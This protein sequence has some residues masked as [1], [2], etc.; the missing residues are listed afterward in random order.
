M[1]ARAERDDLSQR[2]AASQA[3]IAELELA[4]RSDAERDAVTGLATLARLRAALEIEC[5]RAQRQGRPVLV[6]LLDIDGFRKI[7][8]REGHVGGDE[9]L[10]TV[11]NAIRR[12]A[13]P[14]DLVARTGSDEFG[15]MIVGVQLAE[16]EARCQGLMA[17]L[18]KERTN[19]ERGS[20]TV[21]VGV[22]ERR[23]R[24][25][26][27]SLL[28]SAHAALDEARR[29]GGARVSITAGERNAE[30]SQHQQEVVSALARALLERDRYSGEHSEQVTEL[31][32]RVSRELG[33]S[34]DE[35]E[36]VMAAALV[37]D[38]GKVAVPDVV[39][40]KPGS[41]DLAEWQV[42]YQHTIVGE[43]IIRAIPGMGALARIVRHEHER[44]DGMGYPDGLSG[45]AIPLG[46]RI[47]LA[48]DA[49]HAMTSDRPYRAAMHHTKAIE[50]L[51][52]NAG[53]QFDP[54]V[55]EVL[56]GQLYGMR[57]AGLAVA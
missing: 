8:A 32:A 45:D 31:V 50:E 4:M 47:I 18:E 46:S 7:N 35:V 34:D 44:W 24:E 28:W 55:V 17:V 15:L 9:A 10:R 51:V 2:L 48:A 39:L 37:H 27:A 43:R 13:G 6:A 40:N 52:V 14:N 36:R 20:V 12:L 3:R 5:D 57:Q 54:Q 42:I 33:L 29:L 11:G 25:A 22:A 1:R 38:V 56:V 21:S 41:L 49:Y 19:G 23:P 53:S 16:A 26:P 30:V